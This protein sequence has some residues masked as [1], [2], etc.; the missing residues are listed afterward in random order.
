MRALLIAL[1]P[2]CLAL[3]AA[4]GPAT[5]SSLEPIIEAPAQSIRGQKIDLDDH[6]STARLLANFGENQRAYEVL[7]GRP[8]QGTIDLQIEK[9]EARVLTEIG[10]Y[11]KS[12]SLLA[13]QPYIGGRRGYYLHHLQRARLNVLMGKYDRALGFLSVIQNDGDPV[14]DPYRDY[15]TVEALLRT[16]QPAAACEVGEKRLA[17]G[18]PRS[19]TP[20]FETRLLEAYINSGKL[21]DALEFVEVLKARR[22]RWSVLAPVIVREI[23]LL[24]MLGRTLQAIDTALEFIGDPGTRSRAV[25]AVEAVIMRVAADSLTNRAL[26]EFSGTMMSKGRLGDA[27]R[28]ISGL[29]GRALNADEEEEKRLLQGDLFYREKRYSKGF[30]LLETD[31]ENPAY[32]RRAML[33]RARI[34][35]KTGQP[36]ES[37]Y[38]YERFATA[39]P[40][41][42]KAAEALFVAA[43]LH[44]SSGDQGQC[45]TVL[46]RIIATYPSSR[47]SKMATSKMSA[48]Y[49]ERQDYTRG[50]RLIEDAVERSGRDDEDLLYHL[51]TA[52][53]E[54]GKNEMRAKTIEE[55]ETLN[56][57]SFYLDPTITSA[58]LQP[59]ISSNGTVALDG[60][61][62]LLVFL[63]RVFEAR[64]S[65]YDRIRAVLSPVEDPTPF[66]RAAVYIERGGRFLEMGFRDWAEM[67]LGAL[68][69]S[70]TLPARLHFELGVLYDD[71]AM[72]WKSVRSFQRVYYSLKRSR[73]DELDSN[74]A[75]LMHPIPYPSLV[76]ENSARHGVQPHLVYAMIREESRFDFKAVSRAGAMGLM[77]LMPAT[78]EQAADELGFPDGIHKNLF[79]PDINLTFGIWYAANLLSRSDGDPLMMLAGYN[80]GFGNARRWFHGGKGPDGAIASVERI[81][82]RETKAYIKRIVR[83]AHIYHTFYFSPETHR[84]QSVN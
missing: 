37:A 77:Q 47:Y 51:A 11:R 72:H 15:L 58:Y 39:H 84:D 16:S 54:T 33:L 23:D 83:S 49:I 10:L 29:D 74:F 69:A 17:K 65:A 60:A 46:R 27:G 1:M 24:F 12:D 62:G 50:L 82:Y 56:P 76:F 31:F 75:I 2:L 41:D 13:L 19:L 66:E 6:W 64:D 18:I 45:N 3:S 42:R 81:D 35:R 53:G 32:Q 52:Y 34:Y 28:L 57:I 55:I 8:S 79:S 61:D 36:S 25:E 43:D 71:Y 14:F 7:N 44:S 70:G 67:E 21:G 59:V 68:E 30:S 63:K 20:H 22:S 73:R 38:A 26:L 48:Y 9:F 4:I 78:G 40:Y 5:T 80:A